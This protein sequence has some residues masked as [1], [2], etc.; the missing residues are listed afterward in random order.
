[1]VSS[2]VATKDWTW[3]DCE[4]GVDEVPEIF[5]LGEVRLHIAKEQF[6]VSIEL[7]HVVSGNH[8]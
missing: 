5:Y 2:T 3:S 6:K 7:R 8:H 4:L 1:M